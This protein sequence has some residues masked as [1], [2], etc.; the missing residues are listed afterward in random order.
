MP[1]SLWTTADLKRQ[2]AQRG[3]VLLQI[4]AYLKPTSTL[5]AAAALATMSDARAMAGGTDLL[6]AAREK[7][8]R[9]KA[10]V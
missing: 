4:T 1:T 5:E 6:V 8:L 2:A 3:K 10:V 7:G 9:L